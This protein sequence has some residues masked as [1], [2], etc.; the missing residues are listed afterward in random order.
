V[1]NFIDPAQTLSRL[2]RY[3][4]FGYPKDFIFR[5]QKAVKGM[6]A[7]KVL[8]AAKRTLKLDEM[9]VLVVGSRK[10]I[11]PALETLNQ[12]V[13]AVDISIPKPA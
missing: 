10:A 2:M 1:F 13:T 4:Y 3:E 8:E 12:P 9:V 6:T 7:Q 11:Q 5:Y